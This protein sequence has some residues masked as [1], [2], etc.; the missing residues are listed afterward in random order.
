M[1]LLA[2]AFLALV[3]PTAAAAALVV[4]LSV[5]PAVPKKDTPA[6]IQVRPYWPYPRPDGSC[7]VLKPADVSYPFRIEAVS[8]TRRVSRVVV[9]R[10]K[11]RFVWS[12]TFRFGKVG[13][14]TIRA[15]QSGPRYR[16]RYGRPRIRV[17]VR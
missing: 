14:W 15:P 7:C 2:A 5:V 11:N 10:T 8:P 12:G 4:K 17:T 9:R 6:T 3:A 13:R 16:T 1:K